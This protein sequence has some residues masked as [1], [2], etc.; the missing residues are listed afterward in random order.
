MNYYWLKIIEN[1]KLQKMIHL[2]M[3]A[4]GYLIRW[5]DNM[6]TYVLNENRENLI[7]ILIKY[8]IASRED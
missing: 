8:T 2:V 6:S 3:E 4:G 1:W 7:L 5:Y